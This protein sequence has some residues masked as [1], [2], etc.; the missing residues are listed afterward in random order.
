MR[1]FLRRLM[2]SSTVLLVTIFN[3]IS[4]ALLRTSMS[5]LTYQRKKIDNIVTKRERVGFPWRDLLKLLHV[6]RVIHWPCRGQWVWHYYPTPWSPIQWISRQKLPS[7]SCIGWE[8]TFDGGGITGEIRQ[9]ISRF[10]N[11][12]I[13]TRFQQIE[14]QTQIFCLWRQFPDNWGGIN[15]IHE[16]E[17]SVF[18]NQFD[19]ST[20]H[21]WVHGGDFIEVLEEIVD[22]FLMGD[23]A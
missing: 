11:N 7:I 3:A 2:T 20:L 12:G 13:G 5:G 17:S 22:S 23:V 8:G 18:L 10:I 1:S 15:F 14:N 9:R 19:D 4:N 6:L 21:H 16:I